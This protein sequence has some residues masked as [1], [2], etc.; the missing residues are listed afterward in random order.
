MT[1]HTVRTDRYF[2]PTVCILA[3]CLSAVQLA[4]GQ[5][6]SQPSR[7][8]DTKLP[9]SPTIGILLR[10]I[11]DESR[12]ALRK[13]E[14]PLPEVPGFYVDEVCQGGP[15]ANA[16][17]KPMDVLVVRSGGKA[18]AT[19]EQFSNWVSTLV[20]GR[21]YQVTVYRLLD[22]QQGGII[23]TAINVSIK[24]TTHA[25][26][27][28]VGCAMLLEPVRQGDVEFRV[29]GVHRGKVPLRDWL[30]DRT[31]SK[32]ELLVIEIQVSNL[33]QTKKL[34][35]RSW[36]GEDFAFDRD[37]ATLQD[38]FGN[39]YK[40]I[41]FGIGTKV[42]GQAESDSLY[43]LK[44]VSDMLVFELPVNNAE[45]LNLE[46]PAK[47]FGGEGM[48]QLRILMNMIDVVSP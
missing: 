30:G 15:A 11:G 19:R 37:F 7:Q 28:L 24:P 17:I 42:V 18:L 34:E 14:I 6:A 44:S 39:H 5:G 2:A 20:V 25:E 12:A 8:Q 48:I 45:Y 36:M 32:D 40:R 1:R 35:Y 21:R 27:K 31:T 10:E 26:L 41:S 16:G 9:D 4:S 22:N 29:I 43:P 38:N 33:S 23:W 13:R 3:A 47:N 46:L